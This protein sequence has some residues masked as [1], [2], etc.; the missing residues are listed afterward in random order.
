MQRLFCG[1]RGFRFLR[2]RIRRRQ[3]GE[4]DRDFAQHSY[5][6]RVIH[7]LPPGAQECHSDA[8]I[9]NVAQI[10]ASTS[11]L[12]ACFAGRFGPTVRRPIA[13][14][15]MNNE[16]DLNPTQWAA[17]IALL[18]AMLIPVAIGLA[19][20]FKQRYAKAIVRLQAS[21]ASSSPPPPA[22]PTPA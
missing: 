15:S 3:R 8:P 1:C 19:W 16:T 6:A 21:A 13:E 4:H 10:R 9:A 11:R 18:L 5:P 14:K 12:D 17:V 20:W 7:G 22:E 2:D